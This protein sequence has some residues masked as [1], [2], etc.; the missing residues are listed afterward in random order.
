MAQYK[1][2]LPQPTPVSKP[3]WD[4]A[5]RHELQIQHC[6]KCNTHVFYPREV[7][8]ECLAPDL[9]W[10]KVSGKGTLYSYTIAQAPT[11]HSFAEEVP[12][13]IA[14]V[15][16]AEG[17]HLTTNITGCSPETLKVGMPVVAAFEDV[18]P[19]RTLV[20]FRPA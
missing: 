2:P 3:F 9:Q 19:E 15:E 8:P 11:H 4:A 18:T 1:K 13:V 10:V 20:K 7:C 6:N 17:P 14:I 12:Y 5:K 16:L